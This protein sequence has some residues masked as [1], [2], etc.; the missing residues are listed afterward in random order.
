MQTACQKHLVHA[1]HIFCM[2]IVSVGV[3][4]YSYLVLFRTDI[5]GFV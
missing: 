2:E 3:G 5:N 1:V 4:V